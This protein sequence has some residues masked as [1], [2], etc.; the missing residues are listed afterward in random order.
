MAQTLHM[1]MPGD[2]PEDCMSTVHTIHT[3]VLQSCGSVG[4]IVLPLDNG[5]LEPRYLFLICPI[6]CVFYVALDKLQSAVRHW[7]Q[8]V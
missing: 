3:E 1:Y 7:Y 5:D 2:M 8:H 4:R 6:K